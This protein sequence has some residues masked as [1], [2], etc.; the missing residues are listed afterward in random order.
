MNGGKTYRLRMQTYVNNSFFLLVSQTDLELAQ[1]YS[2]R[3]HIRSFLLLRRSNSPDNHF[4]IQVRIVKLFLLTDNLCMFSRLGGYILSCHQADHI[5]QSSPLQ[6][7]Q[8]LERPRQY[9]KVCLYL[10]G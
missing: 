10:F 9:I 7:Y 6:E 1:V 8:D 4:P 2:Y 3:T 5:G